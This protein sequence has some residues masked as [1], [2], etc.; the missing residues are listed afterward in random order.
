MDCTI[1]L[2]H[3]EKIKIVEKYQK[4]YIT[5]CVY[6]LTHCIYKYMGKMKFSTLL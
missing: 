4:K 6:R 1:A 2:L 3:F 5:L